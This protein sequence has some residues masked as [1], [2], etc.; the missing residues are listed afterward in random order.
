MELFRS[1]AVLVE[2]PQPETERLVELLELPSVPEAW[3]YTQLFVEQLYPY[4][5]VYLGAEGMLGGEARDLIA[6]FWRA[7][8]E[9]PPTEPDHLSVLLGLYAHLVELEERAEPGARRDAWRRARTA[10]LWEHLLSWVPFWIAKL[11]RIASP[12]YRAWAG[13]T[14]EALVREAERLDLPRE[15]P[16]ALRDAPPLCTPEAGGGEAFLGQI[17]CPLRTG[18]ILTRTDLTEAASAL[19]LGLRAGERRY[20]L[21]A[22]IGQ[23][24]GGVLGWLAERAA[25]SA[26]NACSGPETIAAF[27]SHQA[28]E[29]SS[30]LRLAADQASA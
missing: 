11:E 10:L 6:G 27:W 28:R 8:G 21:R 7:L 30:V 16:L 26:E 14:R 17:L 4:S 3:E 1:L 13:L 20:A 23:D 12:V 18:L 25:A 22:L 29:A 19:G 15:L 2:P 9:S 5:S 24:P